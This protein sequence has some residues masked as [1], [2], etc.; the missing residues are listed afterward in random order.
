MGVV[1][2]LVHGIFDCFVL[3]YNSFGENKKF[4]QYIYSFFT[5]Q[6]W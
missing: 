2:S 4:L 3:L 6:I 5:A 1:C